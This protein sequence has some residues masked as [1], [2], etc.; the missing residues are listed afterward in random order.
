MCRYLLIG[1]NKNYQNL[2]A[3]IEVKADKTVVANNAEVQAL[4]NNSVLFTITPPAIKIGD[5]IYPCDHN[6]RPSVIKLQTRDIA[7]YPKLTLTT[8]VKKSVVSNVWKY[9]KN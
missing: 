6:S 2:D 5:K 9:S 7:E 8:V 1:L 3:K 4:L